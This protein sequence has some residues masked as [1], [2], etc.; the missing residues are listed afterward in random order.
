MIYWE[1]RVGMWSEVM[2]MQGEP[3]YISVVIQYMPYNSDDFIK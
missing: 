2:Y 1:V 3:P